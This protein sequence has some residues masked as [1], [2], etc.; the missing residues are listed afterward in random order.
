MIDEK[1]DAFEEFLLPRG[2]GRVLENEE[3]NIRE[4]EHHIT[5]QKYKVGIDIDSFLEDICEILNFQR[6]AIHKK[7]DDYLQTYKKNYVALREKVSQYKE[8]TK[9]YFH[10]KESKSSALHQP[11]G[12]CPS[13]KS[14]QFYKV[15]EDLSNL[16]GNYSSNSSF[17][18][19]KEEECNISGNGAAINREVNKKL[20]GFL[21][22]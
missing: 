1:T 15:E 20:I 21:S 19:F 11:S 3:E 5:Q 18:K 16:A 6:D 7:M 14:I 8:K 22:E 9:E 17:V 4:M 13:M 10:S 12:F 2:V